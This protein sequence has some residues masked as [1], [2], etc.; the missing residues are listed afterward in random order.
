M[1]GRRREG[2]R[3]SRTPWLTRTR[4]ASMIP[5][6]GG[7]F[8]RLAVGSTESGSGRG[9]FAY[10]V[11]RYRRVTCRRCYERAGLVPTRAVMTVRVGRATRAGRVGDE[12]AIDA[13]AAGREVLLDPL[14]GQSS[15]P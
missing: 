8:T 9:G 14:A 13:D 7:P 3:G 1:K 4:P 10:P 12:L 6:R 5:R 15:G 2:V 11:D